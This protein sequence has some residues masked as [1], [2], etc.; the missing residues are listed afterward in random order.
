MILCTMQ[1]SQ[2]M[3][4]CVLETPQL[5]LMPNSDDRKTVAFKFS[6][7]SVGEPHP[8]LSTP[9]TQNPMTLP[10]LQPTHTLTSSCRSGS[11]GELPAHTHGTH[12][13]YHLYSPAKGEE[14]ERVSWEKVQEASHWGA[15]LGSPQSSSTR[16]GPGPA[17]PGPLKHTWLLSVLQTRSGFTSL[18]LLQ[19]LS[20]G[21]LIYSDA[22]VRA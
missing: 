9:P 13:N 11:P 12:P 3:S 2:H 19:A 7:R 14:G 22:P 15:A 10:A 17:P 8:G 16:S 1:I 21:G 20:C 6:S 18:G 4:T 5:F